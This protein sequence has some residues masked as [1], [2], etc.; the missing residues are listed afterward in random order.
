VRFLRFSQCFRNAQCASHCAVMIPTKI[1]VCVYRT[2]APQILTVAEPSLYV[3][4][5]C[6][7]M[8]ASRAAQRKQTLTFPLPSLPHLP[9]ASRQILPPNRCGSL[10]SKSRTHSSTLRS[11]SSV[12]LLLY[13]ST[14]SL[15]LLL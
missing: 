2:M 15:I 3:L 4:L 6:T 1:S 7:I 11:S 5:T 14:L 13:S 9:A 12:I 8:R 10:S